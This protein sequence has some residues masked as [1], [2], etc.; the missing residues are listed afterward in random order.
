MRILDSSG[1]V[2]NFL[3]MAHF[4]AS[5]AH[6]HVRICTPAAN[7]MLFLTLQTLQREKS[8]QLIREQKARNITDMDRHVMQAYKVSNK[9]TVLFLDPSSAIVHAQCGGGGF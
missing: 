3:S 2:A 1:S 7:H 5:S 6:W 8:R 9:P 4:H